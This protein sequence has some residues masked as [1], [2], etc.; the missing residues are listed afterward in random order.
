M[1]LNCAFMVERVT[2]IEPR[3]ELGNLTTVPGDARLPADFLHRRA[4]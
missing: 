3:L 1:T 4:P 2:G